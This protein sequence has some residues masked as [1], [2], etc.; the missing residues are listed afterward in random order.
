MRGRQDTSLA[1]GAAAHLR[2]RMMRVVM[3]LQGTVT[4]ANFTGI[5]LLT[6]PTSRWIIFFVNIAMSIY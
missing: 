5:I 2:L 1:A 4:V 3:I 6:A